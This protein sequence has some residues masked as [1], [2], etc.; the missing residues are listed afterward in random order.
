MTT[1]INIV[2]MILH[3]PNFIAQVQGFTYEWIGIY[4]INILIW[5]IWWACHDELEI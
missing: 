2:N 1:C 4:D 5:I 3:I